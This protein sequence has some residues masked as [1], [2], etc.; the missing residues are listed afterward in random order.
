MT[1]SMIQYFRMR[2][3]FRRTAGWIRWFLNKLVRV[4]LS[5]RA[6]WKD[7]LIGG[8]E[9]PITDWRE[10]RLWT[11]EIRFWGI[12]RDRRLFW[13][14]WIGLVAILGILDLP[15][16]TF[17]DNG[18]TPN[19]GFGAGFWEFVT[20]MTIVRV[21]KCSGRLGTYL[22]WYLWTQLVWSWLFLILTTIPF[23]FTTVKPFN[24]GKCV[25]LACADSGR[26]RSTFL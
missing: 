17:L 13:T 15:E 10:R 9:I 14:V 6:G 4:G 22:K 26:Y 11:F 21:C 12:G 19:G 7:L 16:W 5:G 25:T 20:G 1:H 23:D 2:F 3:G 24:Q 8:R 18:C